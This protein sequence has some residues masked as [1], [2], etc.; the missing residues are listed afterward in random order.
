M[1][2]EVIRD[3]I[4]LYD[5]KLCSP[6]SAALV[7]EHIKTCADCQAL[8]EALPKAEIPKADPDEI[9]PFV[10]IR[11]RLRAR[12]IGL[13][14]LGIVLLAVLIPVGYLTVNQIFHINGGT[15]F[16]DLIYKYEMQNKFGK[17]I[18]EG[19]MEEYV[20][21]HEDI[22][23]CDAPDGTEISHQSFYLEKLKAAYEKVKKYDPRV[24]KIYSEYYNHGD[25]DIHRMQYFVLEFTRSNGT[26]LE[27]VIVTS[28]YDGSGYGVPL[29]E[30]VRFAA[31][32]EVLPP[33][34]NL[35]EMFYAVSE[36][37]IPTD[38]RD[39][40]AFV[41]T[42][43]FADGG[44]LNVRYVNYVLNEVASHPREEDDLSAGGYSLTSRFAVSDFKSV[45]NGFTDFMRSDYTL[46]ATFGHER[47]D[48]ERNMFYYPVTLVGSY[49]EQQAIVQIK[50]YYDEYGFHSPRPEDIKGIYENSDLEKKLAG[51][52]G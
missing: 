22:Y 11:R 48:M 3:L 49:E 7:E 20:Q 29:W 10:R 45:Y 6:E 36:S 1:K 19:R 16:E 50:L 46:D 30:D 31:E 32:G 9:K 14:V 4:P 28:L 21:R 17:M 27:M 37:D 33:G 25:N 41:N 23:L 5:E 26:V 42:L 38:V 18:T 43:Y 2:C 24:G 8:L 35:E 44:D 13:I 12:D 51:I 40:Y 52:F 39:I 47:F 34:D 15:D